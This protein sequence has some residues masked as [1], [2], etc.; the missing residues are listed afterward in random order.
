MFPIEKL[1]FIKKFKGNVVYLLIASIKIVC[2]Y[3]SIKPFV[4]NKGI[5][6]HVD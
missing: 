1:I 5:Q 3:M 2:N 6:E 4:Y